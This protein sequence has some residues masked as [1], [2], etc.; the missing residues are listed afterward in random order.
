MSTHRCNF[1]LQCKSTD[2]CHAKPHEPAACDTPAPCGCWPGREDFQP[3]VTCKPESEVK[4]RPDCPYCGVKEMEGHH[5]NDCR[6][7]LKKQVEA[8][9]KLWEWTTIHHREAFKSDYPVSARDLER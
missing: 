2:C 5:P 4:P 3:M 1:S 7:I 6:A 9:R 8:G